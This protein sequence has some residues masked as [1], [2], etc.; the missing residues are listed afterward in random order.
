MTRRLKLALLAACALLPCTVARA[1]DLADQFRDPPNSARPRVWWHWMNGNITRDGIAK[2]LAWMQA[3]GIGGVHVFDVNLMTPQIV[4]HRLIYMTPA[5]QDAFRFAVAE[6]DRR[7]MEVAVASSPGW[8]ETGGPWVPPAD[9]LKKLVWSELRLAP[10]QRAS[11][12]LP[13]LPGAT[14]PFQSLSM[15]PGIAEA[16]TGATLPEPPHLTGEIAVLAVP[17]NAP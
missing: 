1:D 11:A 12:P 7:G 10:G 8:S 2:D 6:A 13:P 5:W 4:D 17:V 3:I 15:Q 14:G 16:A 9:G